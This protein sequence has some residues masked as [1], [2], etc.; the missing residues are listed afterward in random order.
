[1]IASRL[2]VQLK[3]TQ[4]ARAINML[5]KESLFIDKDS[6]IKAKEKGLKTIEFMVFYHHDPDQPGL[7]L[8]NL[9]KHPEFFPK[10][11]YH[12]LY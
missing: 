6:I 11:V 8:T 1:M 2:Q 9:V 4:I 5:S 7:C 10:V 12:L 3:I